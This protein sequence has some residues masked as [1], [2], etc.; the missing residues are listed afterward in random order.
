V[1]SICAAD[2]VKWPNKSL[3][4]LFQ[5]ATFTRPACCAYDF[6]ASAIFN[7]E[8]FGPVWLASICAAAKA[9]VIGMYKKILH[10]S[11]LLRSGCCYRV[12]TRQ[13]WRSA[14]FFSVL[15][16]IAHDGR[17]SNLSFLFFRDDPFHLIVH[18]IVER[19]LILYSPKSVFAHSSTGIPALVFVTSHFNLFLLLMM[20]SNLV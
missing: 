15:A 3:N 8:G 6:V 2:L 16:C 4:Q 5:L 7:C 20:F 17:P 12:T 18:L 11:V 1:R 10:L 13:K 14:L 9:N 19:L